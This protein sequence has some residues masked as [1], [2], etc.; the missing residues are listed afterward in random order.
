MENYSSNPYPSAS[1]VISSTVD[2]TEDLAHAVNGTTSTPLLSE[3]GTILRD[4]SMNEFNLLRS[5]A[6]S[7]RE[8]LQA[9]YRALEADGE[10]AERVNSNEQ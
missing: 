9:F 2:N 4:M 8:S 3:K 6:F 10:E 1:K 7:N 5:I